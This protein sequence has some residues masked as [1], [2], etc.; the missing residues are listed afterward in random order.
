MTDDAGRK[1]SRAPVARIDKIDAAPPSVGTERGWVS[2]VK[3]FNPLGPMAEAYAR[4]LAYRLE[5]KRLA[6]E[7]KRVEEQAKT[8]NNAID[9]TYKLKMEE[10]RH[11]RIAL[12]RTFDL[13]EQQLSQLHIERMQV[14]KMAQMASSKAME[15][16]ISL[17]ER[18]MF[19]DM[20]TELTQ[21]LPNFGD[22]AGKN[23]Q[24]LVSALPAIEMPR[25]LLESGD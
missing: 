4:T 15:S 23:L 9:K 11:R 19:K 20:A 6:L 16:G 1:R 22:Q 17:E 10:L 8:I 18:R 3:A 12:E 25:A 2:V 24:A 14:L 13:A 5:S 7:A 21:Q